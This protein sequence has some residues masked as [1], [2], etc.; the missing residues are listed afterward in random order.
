MEM[1]SNGAVWDE[2]V[3]EEEFLAAAWSAAIEGDQVSMAQECKDF[4]L[5]DKLFYSFVVVLVKALD[6]NFPPIFEFA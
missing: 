4:D 6:C 2:L 3:N 5:I 1:I